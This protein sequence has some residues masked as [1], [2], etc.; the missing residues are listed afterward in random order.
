MPVP[1]L[2]G[3]ARQWKG[4][5]RGPR[6]AWESSDSGCA[7]CGRTRPCCRSERELAS[8]SGSHSTRRRPCGSHGPSS[9]PRWPRAPDCADRCEWL[10][11]WS[12]F[13]GIFCVGNDREI[14]SITA[15]T[16]SAHGRYPFDGMWV[17]FIC[18]FIFFNAMSLKRPRPPALVLWAAR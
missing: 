2:V 17:G 18:I 10:P 1:G 12:L 15:L 5:T 7:L 16:V 9:A 3:G 11:C 13:S 14:L 8:G 4:V 6:S